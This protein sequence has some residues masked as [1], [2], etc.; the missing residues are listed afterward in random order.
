MTLIQATNFIFSAFTVFAQIF[1]LAFVLLLIFMRAKAKVFF[2][3]LGRHRVPFGFLVSLGVLLGSLWY[4]EIV[5]F[6]PCELCWLQRIFFY[7]QTVIFGVALLKKDNGVTDY[8]IALSAIGALI[9]GYQSL[10]QW[11]LISSSFCATSEV[12]ISCSKRLV[13]ELGYITIPL[14]SLTAFLLIIALMFSER[15]AVRED[16]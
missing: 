6:P 2:A 4:S 11:G 7:P 9:A 15:I 3:F 5:G 12:A 16:I 1:L 13:F 10:I 14:M 8:G